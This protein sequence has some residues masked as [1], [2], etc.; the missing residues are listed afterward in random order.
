MSKI[1]EILDDKLSNVTVII[2]TYNRTEEIMYNIKLL[3]KICK[4]IGVNKNGEQLRTPRLKKK[5]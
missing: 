2:P 3:D 5:T 4:K 1:D